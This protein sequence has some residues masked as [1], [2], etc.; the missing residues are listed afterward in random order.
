VGSVIFDFPGAHAP[1][2]SHSTARR[3][4]Q[5]EK[6]HR[7]DPVLRRA[8]PHEPR[9]GAPR[10]R[11]SALRCC[12]KAQTGQRG[13]ARVL[14]ELQLE[15]AHVSV[16]ISEWWLARGYRQASGGSGAE[17]RAR[18]WPYLYRKVAGDDVGMT[19]SSKRAFLSR[20]SRRR[21]RELGAAPARNCSDERRNGRRSW[22][23][24]L[25]GERRRLGEPRTR[26]S[27]SRT[28]ATRR[29]PRLRSHWIVG[30]ARV[31]H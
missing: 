30:P 8:R 11:K 27:E 20:S 3:R 7:R 18:N 5:P 10:R 6:G 28:F 21:Q 2:R 24:A 16:D 22:Q 23:S 29:D 1:C 9:S 12:T 31:V 13:T 25:A 4:R 15:T 14:A 19:R 26:P 17:S